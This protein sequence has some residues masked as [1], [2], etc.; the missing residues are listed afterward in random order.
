MITDEDVRSIKYYITQGGD[1]ENW[2]GWEDK[3]K[4]ISKKYPELIQALKNVQIAEYTL[5]AVA[6]YIDYPDDD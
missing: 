1:I 5:R 4:E 3:K 2:S 6:E